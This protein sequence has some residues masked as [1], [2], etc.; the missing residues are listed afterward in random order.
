M[1]IWVA[2]LVYAYETTGPA[3]VGLVAVAQLVPA[4]IAAP[5]PPSWRIGSRRVARWR[6]PTW[7]S[8]S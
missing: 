6:S 2:I 4:A 3:S 8:A 7:R 1:A 5:R